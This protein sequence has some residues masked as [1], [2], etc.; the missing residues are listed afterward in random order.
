LPYRTAENRIEGVVVTYTDITGLKLAAQALES[1]DRQQAVVV[2]LGRTALAETEAQ[3]LFDRAARAVA[4]QLDC[5]FSE[6]LALLPGSGSFLL[7]A[8]AG[9]KTGSLGRTSP[10]T[11]IGSLA[12]YALQSAGPVIVED[13]VKEERFGL[14]ALNRE[15]G[16]VTVSAS[17]SARR[18]ERW[19]ALC[20]LSSK[21]REFAVD[22]VNFLQAVANV[23]SGAIARA[24]VEEGMRLARARLSAILDNADDAII[25]ID[26]G[27]KITMFN[28]GAEKVFG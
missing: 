18:N 23:L 25:S 16:V 15:H 9:W 14:S 4:E 22:D 6:V 3:A 26:P 27:Q 8:G 1:R 13:V 17:S 2:M 28:H 10:A 5:E 24:L 12:G 7:R 21:R 11:G 20:V 19:G